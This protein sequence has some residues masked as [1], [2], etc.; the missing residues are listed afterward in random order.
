MSAAATAGKFEFCAGC[1]ASENCCVRTRTGLG[2]VA[3]PP[4][5]ENELVLIASRCGRDSSEFSEQAAPF[6]GR[7][8]RQ[9]EGGCYFYH[10]GRCAIYDVRP[11]DCRIFPFDIREIEGRLHWIVYTTLCPVAF[12]PFDHFESAK[13][14]LTSMRVS[15]DELLRFARHGRE[16][17]GSHPIRVLEPVRT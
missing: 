11:F 3:S 8:V 12:E 13:S 14:V 2:R 10:A 5:L 6:G 17:M 16:T 4:L 7:A 15:H 1:G 9:T